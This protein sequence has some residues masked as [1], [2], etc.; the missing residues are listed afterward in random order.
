MKTSF[1]SGVILGRS[2]FN[3]FLRVLPQTEQRPLSKKCFKAQSEKSF[4]IQRIRPE[5]L[6][7]KRIPVSGIPWD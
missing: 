2:L 1:V 5:S 3:S 7:F 4:E 6:K